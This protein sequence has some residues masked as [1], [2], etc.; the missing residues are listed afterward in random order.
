MKK[1]SKFFVLASV[2]F[3]L[4]AGG[5]FAGGAKEAAA[6]GQWKPTKP[7]TIIVPWGAGGSTDQITRVTAGEL[8]QYLGQRVVIV[9][10]PG[11][12]GSV[13]SKNALDAVKDG[14]TWTAGA[15][16]DL[17]TYQVQGMLDTNLQKDWDIFLTVANISI[18]GVNADAP[19]KTFDDLLADFKAKPGQVGVATA[20]QSSAGHIAIELIRSYT[21]IEYKHVTYDGGN[22]A[23]TAVVA[24]EVLVTPQLAVEQVDMIRGGKIRPLAV[25]AD[26]DLT[27]KGY[28]GAIPSIKKWIPDFKTGL[29]YFGIF[30]PKGVPKEVS[31]T[32]EKIWNEKIVNSQKIKDYADDRAAIFGPIAGEAAQKAAFSYYQPVAWLYYEAGKAKVSPDTVGI[33]KP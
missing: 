3:L 8:E 2:C 1:S 18:I 25:L 6:D 5:L 28:S 17:A 15:A 23:V 10:Q 16:A 33:P 30:I 9:N 26:N 12:S 21:G 31:A 13:G 32:L 7:I 29:N 11:A 19:Y 27:L 22:P 4:F 24:G 14:Y 20:G